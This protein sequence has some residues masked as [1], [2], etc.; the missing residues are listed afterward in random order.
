M[1]DALGNDLILGNKYGYASRDGARV[2]TAAGILESIGAVKATIAITE[3]HTF[4][5]NT[6][7]NAPWTGG[8]TASVHGYM[9]FPLKD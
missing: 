3:R 2:N 4:M 5:Y 7:S 9:L 1:K 8:R 6:K